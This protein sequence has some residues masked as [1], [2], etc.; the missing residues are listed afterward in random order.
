[1]IWAAEKVWVRDSLLPS[2][3]AS[4]ELYILCATAGTEKA[5]LPGCTKSTNDVYKKYMYTKF[6]R[7]A[8][9]AP[10]WEK[11]QFVDAPQF[12]LLLVHE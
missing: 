8:H 1:M 6:S 7:D 2:P 9:R 12:K 4:S 11:V 5:V 10:Y 3:T